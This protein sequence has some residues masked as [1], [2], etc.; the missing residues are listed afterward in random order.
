M[1]FISLIRDFKIHKTLHRKYFFKCV[2]ILLPGH[3]SR[4][5]KSF[6]QMMNS[7]SNNDASLTLLR[8]FYPSWIRQGANTQA[9]ISNRDTYVLYKCDLFHT[10]SI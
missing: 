4:Y 5:E 2:R 7:F 9:L 1:H 6:T 10:W 8:T 3:I